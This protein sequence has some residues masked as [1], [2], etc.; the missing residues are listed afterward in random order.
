MS[1]FTDIVAQMGV[2]EVALGPWHCLSQMASGVEKQAEVTTSM[3]CC[4]AVSEC[5]MYINCL[6]PASPW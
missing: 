5:G 6:S 2:Q 3:W 4:V 1:V